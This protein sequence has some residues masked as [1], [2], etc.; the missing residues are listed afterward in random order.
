MTL[1]HNDQTLKLDD[2]GIMLWFS[3]E[4]N[5]W[6]DIFPFIEAFDT[7][8]TMIDHIQELEDSQE[9]D[10]DEDFLHEVRNEK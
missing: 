8:N 9:P 2:S 6:V 7:S 4:L 1:T 3:D 10:T 5:K